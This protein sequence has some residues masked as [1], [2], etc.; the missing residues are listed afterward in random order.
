M[1]A[2]RTPVGWRPWTLRRDSDLPQAFRWVDDEGPVSLTD[3][4]LRLLITLPDGTQIQ[5]QSGVDPGFV[6]L[7]QAPPETRGFFSYQPSPDLLAQMPDGSAALYKFVAE[8]EGLLQV[9]G[10]GQIVIRAGGANG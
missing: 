6:V 10:E 9:I 2:S 4:T 3:K 1:S 7:E 8:Y 5:R